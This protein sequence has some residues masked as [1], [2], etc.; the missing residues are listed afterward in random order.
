MLR[1][2]APK[3]PATQIGS[4]H[5]RY[6]GDVRALPGLKAAREGKLMTQEDLAGAT[7]INRVTISRLE[8]GYEKARFSTIKRLA[9]A[10]KVEP[11]LLIDGEVSK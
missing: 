11:R 2:Q 8:T 10:L 9:K 3:L 4:L 5:V 6:D 7:K 1:S